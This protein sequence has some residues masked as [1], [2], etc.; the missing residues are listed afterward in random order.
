MSIQAPKKGEVTLGVKADIIEV[1]NAEGG[2]PLKFQMRQ[3]VPNFAYD[4]VVTSPVGAGNV[5]KSFD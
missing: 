4:E 3:I 2:S 5:G 1:M